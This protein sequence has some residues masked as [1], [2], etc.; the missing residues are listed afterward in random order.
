[1]VLCSVDCVEKIAQY[2]GVPG[3]KIY[4]SENNIVASDNI[5]KN[6]T[7]EGFGTI[8]QA[9]VKD[10]KNQDVLGKNKIEQALTKQ[11]LEYAVL[12]LNYGDIPTNAKKILKELNGVLQKNTYICGTNLTIA[13]IVFFHT[14]H[15]T[16]NN[17]TYQEK[18][19]YINVSRWFDNV[20]Q[21]ENL[22]QKLNLIDFNL[23]YL[24][25]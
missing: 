3:R 4:M 15:P 24:Y 22:R 2:L 6:Q 10:S 20:Q 19:Q 21:N 11:W 23:M 25:L 18:A 9:L 12:Y 1:M 13:D 14:L 16:M 8:V 7:I 17:L 5:V